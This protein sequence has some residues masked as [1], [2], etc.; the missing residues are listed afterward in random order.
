MFKIPLFA[1]IL[2]SA[3]VV[4]IISLKVDSGQRDLWIFQKFSASNF[5]ID[6]MGSLQHT[7]ETVDFSSQNLLSSLPLLYTVF[8]PNNLAAYVTPQNC[9][10]C[11]LQSIGRNL[12]ITQLAFGGSPD[13]II[14]CG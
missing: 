7:A 8:G 5:L 14:R 10:D 6:A 13:L 4:L 11:V 9:P 3:T 1:H 12:N 2:D